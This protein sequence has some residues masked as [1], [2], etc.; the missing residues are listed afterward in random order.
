MIVLDTNVVS[1]LMK[2]VPDGRVAG[3]VDARPADEMFI[4]AITVAELMYG[5]AA[6]P[7]GQRKSNLREAVMD[8][9][10]EDF[11]GQVLPFGGEA[12]P[13]YADLVVARNRAG[14]PA[15][16]LDAQIAAI[17][18]Q[19]GATLVTRNTEDFTDTGVELVDPWTAP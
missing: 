1:E 9:V 7:A 5:V 12:A 19:V 16:V 10:V 11:R 18:R 4:T 6:L 8:L 15:G 13:H 3:W 14:R 2:P 17:C